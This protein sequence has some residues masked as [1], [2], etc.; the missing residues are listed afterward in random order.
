MGC[1][2]DDVYLMNDASDG[3]R[4]MF[5]KWNEAFEHDGLK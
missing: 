3:L 4:N 1:F 5:L 2:T